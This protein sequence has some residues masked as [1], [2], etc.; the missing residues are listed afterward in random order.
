[1]E[2]FWLFKAARR[3]AISAF[4]EKGV[5]KIGEGEWLPS[6]GEGDKRREP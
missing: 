2:R 5:W 6:W 1:M 3:R 4:R